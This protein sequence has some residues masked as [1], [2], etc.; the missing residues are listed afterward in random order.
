MGRAWLKKQWFDVA[1]EVSCRSKADVAASGKGG[2]TLLELLE[3]V[4]EEG[5]GNWTL[6]ELGDE[7]YL[8]KKPA[9][10]IVVHLGAPKF[11]QGST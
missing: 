11:V 9:P 3:L 6:F 2:A 10:E 5:G 7:Y 8:V 4:R 1:G